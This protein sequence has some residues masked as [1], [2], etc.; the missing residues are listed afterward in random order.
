MKRRTFIPCLNKQ[1]KIYN[2]SIGSLIGC[3]VGF[4]LCG[5]SAGILWGL[6]GAALGFS[7]GN[8]LASAWFL[9]YAQ[10]FIYWNFPYA[11]DWLGKNIPESSDKEEL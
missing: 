10:R 8:W 6:V 5:L 2:F 1:R 4:A 9:G 7:F 3:V 11:K